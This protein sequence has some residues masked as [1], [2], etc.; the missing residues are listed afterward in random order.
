MLAGGG[1]F[2]LLFILNFT[3]EIAWRS[4]NNKFYLVYFREKI[5][6]RSRLLLIL[7]MNWKREEEAQVAASV[8]MAGSCKFVNHESG[9]GGRLK[10]ENCSRIKYLLRG[11]KK[12][13]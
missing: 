3:G 6:K 2:H 4:A 1:I 9:K 5:V 12:K 11:T 8:K 7:Q 13:F 10:L